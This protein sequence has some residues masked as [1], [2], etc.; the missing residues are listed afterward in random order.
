MA[1]TRWHELSRSGAV[2]SQNF[3]TYTRNFRV[4]TDS[5]TTG[6][7]E[8]SA[9]IPIAIWSSYYSVEDESDPYALAKSIQVTPFA[10]TQEGAA[11]DYVVT[12][13]NRP[14]DFGSINNPLA[15]DTPPGLGASPSLPSA[16]TPPGGTNP[17][18]RPWSLKFGTDNTQF[19]PVEDVNGD[20]IAASN[21][22]RYA[23]V[24][25]DRAI[26]YFSLSIPRASVNF[27]KPGTYVNA[28]N[29]DVFFGYNVGTVRCTQYEISSVYEQAWGY[30]YQVDLKFQINNDGWDL[31]MIDEGNYWH[32]GDGN[33]H[34][35][36]DKWSNPVETAVWL[37]GTGNRNLTGVP[38]YNNFQVYPLRTFDNIL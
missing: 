23:G 22:Q 4:Y 7:I 37:D 26:P 28:I 15:G 12:Y 19:S 25:V 30:F 36:E 2:D 35:A 16:P 38:V 3:R 13:D 6:P 14:F 27:S 33:L 10:E 8:V 21:T 31:K 34:M 32:E 9:A 20:P 18:V 1:V 24:T 29:G 5:K 11:W 17:A